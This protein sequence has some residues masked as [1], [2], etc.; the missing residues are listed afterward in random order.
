MT[1]NATQDSPVVGLM[2]TGGGARAAYQVGVIKAVAELLPDDVNN[3]F[4]VITGT[5]AGAINAA[6]LASQAGDFRAGAQRLEEVWANLSIGMV[7]RHDW[8]TVFGTGFKWALSLALGGLGNRNPHSLLDNSPLRELLLETVGFRRI[9]RNLAS[10]H[11]QALGITVSGYTSARSITYYQCHQTRCRPWERSRRIGL[12]ASIR[13]EHLMASS[14]MPFIFP[15]IQVG[16]EFCGDG[17]IRQS[18]PLSPAIHLGADRLLVVGVRNEDPN[19]LPAPGEPVEYP[20]FGH[21]AGYM[22]DTLFM[23]ALQSDVERLQRINATLGHVS[24]PGDR[25]EIGLRHVDC[26]VVV[27]SEDVREVAR[28][29]AD[30]FPRTVRMLLAGVGALDTGG[31]QLMSYL[32]FEGTYTRELIDLGY[33]D[34]MQRRDYMRDYLCGREAVSPPGK[35]SAAASG[36]GYGAPDEPSA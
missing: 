20:T 12:P 16:R 22:L 32:L 36:Q 35:V 19:D 18:A 7:Y 13:V 5:S 9:A 21:I 17:V 30:R 6:V 1:A 31:R 28:R 3:P 11:L 26:E 2:L 10:G 33:R 14:A 29:H 34:T 8:R 15:A 24:K 25:A 4:P 27:P 23:D